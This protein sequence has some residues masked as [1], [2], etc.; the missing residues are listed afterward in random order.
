VRQSSRYLH[1]LHSN[2]QLY[3]AV[4]NRIGKGLVFFD[5][6]FRIFSSIRQPV[7]HE[8]EFS[9]RIADVPHVFV[10]WI[11]FRLNSG[12]IQVIGGM[13]SIPVLVSDFRQ[14]GPHNIPSRSEKRCRLVGL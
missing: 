6:P 13:L 4:E 5:T 11:Y 1:G 12:S 3:M 10:K 8:T 7:L 14:V 9:A 2:A